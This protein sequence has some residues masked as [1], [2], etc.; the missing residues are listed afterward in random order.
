M[1]HHRSG[2]LDLLHYSRRIRAAGV[3]AVLGSA[4][5]LGACEEPE[6]GDEGAS[7]S[8]EVW[9]VDQSDSDHVGSFGGAMHVFAGDDLMGASPGDAAPSRSVD[10]GAETADLCREAT[11]ANPV[12][13]HMLLFNER[14]SHA[15]LSFVASGHVV[16]YDAASSEPLECFRMSPGAGDS[17]QAHAAF[18]SPDGT[19][20]VVANQNGKL[21]E[22]IDTDF[23]ANSFRHN[24][25]ATLDLAGGTTPRGHPK[26]DEILRPDNAPIC[27]VIDEQGRYAWVTLRGGGLFVVDARST[28]MQ[29]VAEYDRD[30]VKGNGCGGVQV[31]NRMFLNSGGAPVNLGGEE[32]PHLPLHGF[33]VYRFPID[34]YGPHNPVNAP[35]PELLF[36]A[37][38]E[39]DSHGM[40]A[41]L[42]GR[43]VWVLDRHADLAEVL[44]VE[45]GGHAGTVTLAGDLSENPAPDLVDV[46]PSGDRL[47][48]SL[49][50]P[51]P[52]TGDPHNATGTTP[53]LGIIE[54][55][56]DGTDG[57]LIGIVPF[58]NVHEGRELADPH[59]V[60]VRPLE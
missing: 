10:L 16:I 28:P 15:V 3:L 50:G 4:L 34:G 2:I 27:P 36:S 9:I 46:S 20:I 43:H 53:G 23:E 8:F 19:Y 24:T 26:E 42:D 48:V 49:R 30:T 37:E 52:L 18:P 25:E 31:G 1:N 57:S 13:P 21:L 45:G 51:T 47:F 56:G 7:S 14:G 32:H 6:A 44:Q 41:V 17:Q 22:R 29:I 38:G 55:T 33:D 59:A 11:G 60:R 39:R 40:A 54:V 35:A 58:T 5:T 12:R